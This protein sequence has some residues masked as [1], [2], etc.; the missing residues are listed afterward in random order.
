MINIKN[1]VTMQKLIAVLVISAMIGIGWLA[2]NVGPA[3]S[4]RNFTIGVLLLS[5]AHLS[6]FQ[7]F[8][9]RL[10][11]HNPQ[12]TRNII[13]LFD[14]PVRNIKK[15][16]AAAEKL[17]SQNPDLLF[18]SSTPASIAIKKATEIKKI[19]VVFAPVND[20]VAAG[21]VENMKLPGGNITG[22]SLPRSEGRRFQYLLEIAPKIKKV[23]VPH[24]PNDKSGKLSIAAIRGVASHFDI[25]IV[26]GE[27]TSPNQVQGLIAVMPKDI[28][29]IF[30]PRDGTVGTV[31]K[32]FI[33]LASSRKLPL[34]A[35]SLARVKSGALFSYGFDTLALGKQ[36]AYM[37]ERI[38]QGIPPADLP[39]EMAENHL[40][41]NIQTANTIGLSI[42][43]SIL[44]QASIIIR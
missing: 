18:V 31:S 16:E 26:Y 15:L 25:D 21:L 17:V 38:L 44:R 1:K 4:K 13:Y 24:N 36:A 28:D 37:S 29:A 6:V 10:T 30:L 33:S 3:T 14:G 40:Y 9:D 2:W 19:P 39:I 20:P 8:K 11:E 41:I 32:E 7:G 5:P 27:I 12:K 35:P 43:K 22:V 23:Y 34:S 42:P